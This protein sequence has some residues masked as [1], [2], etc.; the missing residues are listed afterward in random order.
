MNPFRSVGARL[1]LALAV[2]VAAALGL[3][4]VIVVPSL[5]R[6]LVHSKVE[7]LRKSLP[8]IR[9]QVQEADTANLDLAL[10]NAAASADARVSYFSEL[11]QDTL[12][13]L[14][15]RTASLRPI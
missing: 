10:Q 9:S 6:N 1:S 5:E 2:V 11:D 14:A 12:I 13:T 4:D 7:Q 3:V 15:T 8:A